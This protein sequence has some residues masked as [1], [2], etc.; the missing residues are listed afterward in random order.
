MGTG[1]HGPCQKWSGLLFTGPG[2]F[3]ALV[4]GGSPAEGYSNLLLAKR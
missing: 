4:A 1:D 3:P 2:F